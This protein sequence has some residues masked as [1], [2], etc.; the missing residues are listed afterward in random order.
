M[1]HL[2]IAC[3]GIASLGSLCAQEQPQKSPL[4]AEAPKIASCIVSTTYGSAALHRISGDGKI[5]AIKLPFSENGRDSSQRVVATEDG[6]LMAYVQKGSL[7]Y[8]TVDGGKPV[9]VVKGYPVEELTPLG[10]SPDGAFLLYVL[11]PPQME[12]APP[13]KITET[14]H[15]LYEVKTK[16]SREL[17]LRGM[18]VGWLPEGAMLLHDQEHGTLASLAITAGASPKVILKDAEN[19]GQI[20]LSP[21]GKFIA[22]NSSNP[23]DTSSAE[24]L[25]VELATGKKSPLAGPG[26]W[27]ELQWPKWSP[28]GKQH[29][30]LTQV[31]MKEGIPQSVLTID[32]KNVTKPAQLS[33]FYWLTES[34]VV[35]EEL[36]ALAVLDAATGKELNRK[37]IG[38]KQP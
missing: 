22:V 4:P 37:V 38:K 23:N 25:V 32:G 1:K 15:F 30:W 11:G 35:L 2:L 10:W 7:L 8:R 16:A 26:A 19:Y 18:L 5:T 12:D 36:E 17:K 33:D 34:V 31:S 27:A 13:S 24:L 28:S 6:S 21:D 20:S 29:A 14:K 3:A 9:S